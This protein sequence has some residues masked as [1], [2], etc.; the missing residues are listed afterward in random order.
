MS[1]DQIHEMMVSADLEHKG[2]I[3]FD[4]FVKIMKSIFKNTSSS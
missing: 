2:R 3:S 4:D 1:K